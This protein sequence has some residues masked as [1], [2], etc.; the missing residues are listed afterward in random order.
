[1]CNWFS[2]QLRLPTMYN[3][4]RVCEPVN[5]FVI[6]IFD[7]WM[8]LSTDSLKYRRDHK[9]FAQSRK[10]SSRDF[11]DQLLHHSFMLYR[12]PKGVIALL[13]DV[14]HIFCQQNTGFHCPAHIL[15][16]ILYKDASTLWERCDVLQLFRHSTDSAI[17]FKSNSSCCLHADNMYMHV[18]NSR[19]NTHG[20]V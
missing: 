12:K 13:K 18:N 8:V 20:A 19:V 11:C 17:R 4:F 2:Y 15:S 7:N 14:I 5:A 1:M 6:A 16:V 10:T 3:S 9:T